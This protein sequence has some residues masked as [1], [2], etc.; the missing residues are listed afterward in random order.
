MFCRSLSFHVAT[1]IFIL[2]FR[3]LA[4]FFGKKSPTNQP[5]KKPAWQKLITQLFK[6]S[7]EVIGEEKSKKLSKRVNEGER[8][9]TDCSV[10]CQ[11]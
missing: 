3:K 4:V 10:S 7:F 8:I 6:A 1:N 2:A 5:I 9:K 11:F